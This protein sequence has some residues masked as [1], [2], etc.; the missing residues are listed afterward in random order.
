MGIVISQSIKNTV[1]TYLGFVIGAINVLFLFTNFLSDY[2]FGLITFILST[3]NIM[4]PIMAFGVQNTIIKFYSSFKTRQSQNSFLTLMLFLPILIIIPVGLIGYF[5]FDIISH[6]LAKENDI[7]GDYVYLIFITSIAFAYFEVF[8]SWS[9]VQMKSVFGNFMKEVFHRICITILLFAL[10]L[11]YLTVNQLIFSIVGVYILRMLIM[12]IYAFSLRFPVI[13]FSKI[14]GLSSILKYTSLIIIAG[15]VANV[16]LEIDKFML[17]QYVAIENVAYYGVA[18]YIATVIGVPY[19]SL[20]Q[21]AN[22][23]TAKYLNEKNSIELENFYKKSSLNLFIISGLIFLL[24][25][26]NINELYKLIPDEFSGGLLVVF[27]ISFSKLID[28]IL[29][30]NNAI[31]FNSN[32]YR[33]VLVLGA[34]LAVLTVLFNLY[35][36]PKYG[37]NGAA[38]ASFIAIFIYNAAKIW[39][40]HAKFRMMP[41]TLDTVKTFVLI[42]V[43]I[44]VFY[45]WDFSFSPIINIIIKSLIITLFY[46][47]IV[48]FFR[49]SEDISTIIDYLLKK[50]NI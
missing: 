33:M 38:F 36:I 23:L 6:W 43:S 20:H 21:I 18:V 27:L 41:F 31:L 49:F 45:F 32:Y 34:F 47:L 24:I 7:I 48:Y 3:A 28:S 14:N 19:R 46:G 10:Y 8:Y 37:L 29:G 42:L 1:I 35:F 50:V 5:S 11:N 26:L 15:S 12:K 39:F 9:K 13:K 44:G 30:N 40:V 22:P 2:Y 17:G 25:I 16:I 4:M